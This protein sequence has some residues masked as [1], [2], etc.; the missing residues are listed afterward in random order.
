[1]FET[2]STDQVEL[3]VRPPGAPLP[4][5]APPAGDTDPG[6]ATP[7]PQVALADSGEAV[8]I[9][10]DFSPS[11]GI[12]FSI[13]PPGGTFGT[14]GSIGGNLGSLPQNPTLAGNAAGDVMALWMGNGGPTPAVH[15]AR[16]ASGGGFAA[17]SKIG[18]DPG[19]GSASDLDIAIDPAGNAIAVWRNDEAGPGTREVLR[20]AYAPAGQP[21]GTT[22]TLDDPGLNSF[23]PDVELDAQ[24][25]AVLTWLS[26]S[27]GN[28]TVRWSARPAGPDT[29]PFTAPQAV[30]GQPGAGGFV[31]GVQL[32]VDPA[33]RAV[34]TWKAEGS[35]VGVRYA[36]RP[37]AGA[38]GAATAMSGD[39]G[40]ADAG[41][42]AV[43]ADGT[44]RV[45]AAWSSTDGSDTRLR[46]ARAAP[47][48]PFGPV[49]SLPDP[50]EGAGNQVAADLAPGG[51]GIVLWNSAHLNEPS[52]HDIP[53]LG[54]FLDVTPPVVAAGPL[55]GLTFAPLQFSASV[56][57]DFAAAPAVS[58]SFGDGGEATGTQAS[59]TYTRPG[60]FQ[61]A[62]SATDSV[63]NGTTVP[64]SV[65]IAL[66]HPALRRLSM[67]RRRFAPS[68]A[69]TPVVARRV[70]R[71]SAFRF[72]LSEAAT[73]RIAIQRA[74]PG[75]RVGRRCVRPR[76]SLTHARRCTR[77]VRA[78]RTLVRRDLAAGAR[79]IAFSGRIGRRA[80]R[81]GRHRATL[82]AANA[83]GGRSRRARIGFVILRRR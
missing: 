63:G 42:P 57:D 40:S 47:G 74:R 50:P 34:V 69:A 51:T 36:L 46:Y 14:V 54:S 6:S 77:W 31:T 62:V 5:G 73:V 76:P 43:A 26:T 15:F 66:S 78:G 67:L 29:I 55:A 41:R 24:G 4:V 1:M 81:R 52:P 30:P 7:A 13:R 83:A 44:G 53:L 71:G 48:A 18:G 59:H 32:A 58:W 75:R 25:R 9:W 17:G 70:P 33:G 37:P 35:T 22:R 3:L 21:F 61:A 80:L 16:K 72:R 11:P 8:A 45:L 20:W 65:G 82:R 28:Q 23:S 10:E 19:E 39:P 49:Q 12:R 60:S 64:V 79:R 56:S 68:S 2:C 27:A 38:F